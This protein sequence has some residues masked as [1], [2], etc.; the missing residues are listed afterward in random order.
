MRPP[1]GPYRDVH[2][3][4]LT[5]EHSRYGSVVEAHPG[6]VPSS[7]LRGSRL[8]SQRHPV[9]RTPGIIAAPLDSEAAPEGTAGEPSVRDDL[10]SFAT[11][12]AH[13]QGSEDAPSRARRPGPSSE[14]RSGPIS[15]RDASEVSDGQLLGTLPLVPAGAAGRRRSV[16]RSLAQAFEQ[17]HARGAPP[18]AG[19]AAGAMSGGA[20]PG[21]S[22]LPPHEA[23]REHTRAGQPAPGIAPGDAKRGEEKPPAREIPPRGQDAPGVAMQP[24]IG[25]QHG[26]PAPPGRAPGPYAGATGVSRGPLRGD[27]GLQVREQRCQRDQGGGGAVLRDPP[28]GNPHGGGREG[29]AAARPA[30]ARAG[31]GGAGGSVGEGRG[32]EEERKE[33]QGG[34]Q[35]PAQWRSG[36]G[37]GREGSDAEARGHLPASTSASMA[38]LPPPVHAGRRDAASARTADSRSALL[39]RWGGSGARLVRGSGSGGG[40]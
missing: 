8:R 36:G 10:H 35:R 18:S 3:S 39:V 38:R 31:G 37:G 1:S 12:P 16:R 21:V 14:T 29:G 40:A 26:G 6:S 34:A 7:P 4:Y 17:A 9:H 22:L 13:R 27:E 32:E 19:G 20:S 15:R 30:G 23:H 28:A 24:G 5:A 11:V 33:G 2:A 25:H